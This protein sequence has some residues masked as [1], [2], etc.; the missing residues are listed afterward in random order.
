M[1]LI[2][3]RVV[4]GLPQ[5]VSVSSP[6]RC[7]PFGRESNVLPR[8][9][10][11]PMPDTNAM[12]SDTPFFEETQDKR[13]ADRQRTNRKKT[14]FFAEEQD[15]RKRL[16]GD[17]SFGAGQTGFATPNIACRTGIFNSFSNRKRGLSSHSGIKTE[18][19]QKKEQFLVKNLAKRNIFLSLLCLRS[20]KVGSVRKMRV[21]SIYFDD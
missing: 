15:M 19:C 18:K 14:L 7:P 12:P 5:A 20:R 6:P 1:N 9:Q 2:S 16:S 21:E 10:P 17:A 4:C 13:H 11:Y 8:F 3:F